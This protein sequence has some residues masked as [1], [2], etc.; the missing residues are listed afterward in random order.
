MQDT[1]NCIKKLLYFK[2][3]VC[4]DKPLIVCEGKTDNIYLRSALRKLNSKFGTL[5]SIDKGK[6]VTKIRFLRHSRVEHDV[7]ELSGGTGN[8]ANLVARYEKAVYRY[9]HRPLGHP[10]IIVIDNDS[11]SDPVF[12]VMKQRKILIGQ[13]SKEPFY[14]ICF[15]LYVVKTPEIGAKGTSCIEDLFDSATRNR[16]LDGKSLSL[17]KEF[18]RTSNF[19]KFDFADRV[20]SPNVGSIDFDGFIP[21]LDRIVAVTSHYRSK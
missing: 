10:V 21:L 7:L 4:L 19:G 16:K 20:V 17:A 18:D 5:A 15:N 12:G 9:R 13:D 11:G 14:H 2:H 6:L 3:F 1:E 8:L